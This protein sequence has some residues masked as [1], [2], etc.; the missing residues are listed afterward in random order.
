MRCHEVTMSVLWN[1]FAS[2]HAFYASYYKIVHNYC[3][4]NVEVSCTQFEIQIVLVQIIL[5]ALYLACMWHRAVDSSHTART[6]AGTHNV[7]LTRS[8]YIYFYYSEYYRYSLSFPS[9]GALFQLSCSFISIR[10]QRTPTFNYSFP[11]RNICHLNTSVCFWLLLIQDNLWSSKTR[12]ID[13]EQCLGSKCICVLWMVICTECKTGLSKV[14]HF[15]PPILCSEQEMLYWP[16]NSSR[17]SYPHNRIWMPVG[18]WDPNTPTSFR[19]TAAQ[20]AVKLSAL[21]AGRALPL[22]RLRQT[23]GYSAAGKIR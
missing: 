16:A 15:S 12:N 17:W 6:H 11:M 8:W 19:H 1:E 20:M 7:L 23:Q 18:L 9:H 22:R 2:D 13:S 10:R 14:E 3:N 4:N 5:S 21:L